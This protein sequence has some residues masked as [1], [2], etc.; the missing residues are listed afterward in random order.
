[1]NVISLR[2]T[3]LKIDRETPFSDY[4]LNKNKN[5]QLKIVFLQLR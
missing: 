2:E 1:M 5:N 3:S 4:F